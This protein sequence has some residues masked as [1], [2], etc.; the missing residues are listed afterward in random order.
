MFARRQQIHGDQAEV[1]RQCHRRERVGEDARQAIGEGDH[2]TLI[3]AARGGITLQDRQIAEIHAVV[4]R[5]DQ[6]IGECG[7]IAQSQIEALPG[8]RVQTVRGIADQGEP[9]TNRFAR[10]HQIERVSLAIADFQQAAE[11]L[12]E[13]L[14]QRGKECRVVELHE[15]IDL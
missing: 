9:R 7:D 11:T 2:A 5:F 6:H 14:L 13:A 15:R 3:A 8:H 1:A 4:Q 10:P 12:T